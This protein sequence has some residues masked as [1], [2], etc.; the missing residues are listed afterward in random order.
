MATNKKWAAAFNK[1]M[2]EF[3]NDPDAFEAV[4]K[5]AFRY[6]R[7]RLAGKEPTYGEEAAAVFAEY[8]KAV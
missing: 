4:E 7:E 3:T 2:D 8:L 5:T 6:L 1:W